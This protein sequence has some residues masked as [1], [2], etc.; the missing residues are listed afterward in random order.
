MDNMQ[1]KQVSGAS[2]PIKV[3]IHAELDRTTHKVVFSDEWEATWKN[4]K[5][6]G[7][8]EVP[9]GT[10]KTPIHFTLRDD[11]G[12]QLNFMN[13]FADVIY[14]GT[15]GTCP[16][17]R[18]NQGGQ[19]TFI[20]S[21]AHLLKV[22][23]ANSGAKCDMKYALRF[24]GQDNV[25]GAEN[26]PYVYDPDL[27]NGGGGIGGFNQSLAY[28]VIGAAAVAALAYLAYTLFLD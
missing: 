5:Q 21:V 14:V 15:D 22:N 11:T 13:N 24:N 1:K 12:L 9:Y 27:K 16:P 19:I 7:A 17:P 18:G 28:V 26:Q 2:G 25:P 4:G 23:N 10:P 20:S 3:E 6:K 8:I